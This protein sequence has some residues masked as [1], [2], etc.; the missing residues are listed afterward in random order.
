MEIVIIFLWL[1]I[2]GFIGSWIGGLGDKGNEKNG[3]ILGAIFGPLGLI[4]AALIPASADAC[5]KSSP[6]I[7]QS[8][9]ELARI[10]VLEAE[11][12]LLKEKSRLQS[13]APSKPLM[14][15]RDKDGDDNDGGIPT[16][17]LD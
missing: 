3:F 15:K 9:S 12:A 13:K 10:A 2:F 16:Y 4:L 6:V 1:T 14:P 8:Q 11:L 5:K 17:R 7:N